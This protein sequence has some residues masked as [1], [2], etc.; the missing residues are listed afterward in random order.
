MNQGE[1][2]NK[3]QPLPH[4][5]HS[6][7]HHA[8]PTTWAE[9]ALAEEAAFSS[10]CARGPSIPTYRDG[11]PCAQKVYQRKRGSA[12]L[13]GVCLISSIL[14]ISVEWCHSGTVK[15]HLE[16]G[17]RASDQLT[18]PFGWRPSKGFVSSLCP[19]PKRKCPT[20]VLALSFSIQI[21]SF[22]TGNSGP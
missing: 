17:G 15:V 8:V 3:T 19:K 1:S 22:P 4:H 7:R 6:C 20:Q 13:D 16:S 10:H 11:S 14:G 12:R 21:A 2:H 9:N 5:F 18:L